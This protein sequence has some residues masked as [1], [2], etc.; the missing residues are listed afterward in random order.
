MNIIPKIF[1]SIIKITFKR[2]VVVP[3]WIKTIPGGAFK[4]NNHVTEVYIPESVKYIESGAFTNSP[5]VYTM[6]RQQANLLLKAQS[7]AVPVFHSID[8]WFHDTWYGALPYSKA[9]LAR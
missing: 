2:T 4:G 5:T 7:H 1:F 3:S 6:P 9:V 8:I